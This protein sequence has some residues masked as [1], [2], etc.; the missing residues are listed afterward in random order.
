MLNGSCQQNLLGKIELK[1]NEIDEMK[2]SK[3]KKPCGLF[4]FNADCFICFQKTIVINDSYI[5]VILK[6]LLKLISPNLGYDIDDDDIEKQK[7]EQH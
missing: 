2:S 1:C 6:M 5:P 7:Q 3:E 4:V